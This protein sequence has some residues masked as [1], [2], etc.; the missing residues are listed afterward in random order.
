[1]D[2]NLVQLQAFMN[3]FRI[4]YSPSCLLNIIVSLSRGYNGSPKL[5]ISMVSSPADQRRENDLGK[6]RAFK[7]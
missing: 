1:M 7:D 5:L 4:S 3:H 2:S 6:Q